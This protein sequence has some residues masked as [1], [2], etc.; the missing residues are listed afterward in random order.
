MSGQSYALGTQKEVNDDC[1]IDQGVEVPPYTDGF[2]GDA[3]DLGAFETGVDPWQA[4]ATIDDN[5]WEGC[6]FP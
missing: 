6:E 4:G 5:A 2:Q 1:G 3:P